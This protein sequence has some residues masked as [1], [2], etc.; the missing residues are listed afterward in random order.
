MCDSDG[1]STIWTTDSSNRFIRT[2]SWTGTVEG[3][4]LVTSQTWD[5]NNDLT[6]TSDAN[7]NTTKY[8][9]DSGGCGNMVEMQLPR[10]NH[11]TNG[12]LSPFSTYSYDQYR[13]VTAY[14][15]PAYN[16]NNGNS[17]VDSPGDNLCS[18]GNKTTSLTFYQTTNEPFGCLTNITKPSGYSTNLS[19]TD[20][21]LRRRLA[22]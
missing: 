6:S 15:D 1:H 14:C 9:Y 17:W 10:A 22:H 7:S 19:Y 3:S 5:G 12:P 18:G 16:Q 4:W 8:G 21:G 11:I 2:Q 13:N 20:G